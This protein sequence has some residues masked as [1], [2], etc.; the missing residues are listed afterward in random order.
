MGECVSTDANGVHR[1]GRGTGRR[2]I[3][4]FTVV[5]ALILAASQPAAA[6]QEFVINSAAPYVDLSRGAIWGTGVNNIW[7]VN[8]LSTDEGMCVSVVN[9]NPTSGHQFT[10]SVFSTLDQ[11]IASYNGGPPTKWQ[12]VPTFASGGSQVSGQGIAPILQ[13]VGSTSS[14]QGKQGYY[15]RTGGAARVSIQFAGSITQAGSPDTADLFVVHNISGSTCGNNIIGQNVNLVNLAGQPINSNDGNF[16]VE[17]QG[18]NWNQVDGVPN[19][20]NRAEVA[21]M[22]S[23]VPLTGYN[24]NWKF[25]GATWDRELACSLQLPF[26]LTAAGNT[27]I[28]P[29]GSG[30]LR[31]CHIS[32]STTAAE[33]VKVTQGT[34]ANC[35]TGP[36]DVTGLFKT[37]QSMALDFGNDSPLRSGANQALCLN[38]SA[39]QNLGGVVIYAPAY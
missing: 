1:N 7:T 13:A 32:F 39:A 14:T 2:R 18:V 28:I 27:Q 26:N 19:A 17:P 33:D 36:A 24:F 35:A 10:I 30:V 3:A 9:N 6:Q 4:G 37:V 29:A 31:V 8:T 15:F 25:N 23:L 16:P 20:Q 34:G 21:I 12:P 5:G 38:Q 22:G 11:R